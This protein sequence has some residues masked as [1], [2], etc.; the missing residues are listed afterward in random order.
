MPWVLAP[1]YWP[2]RG[3]AGLLWLQDLSIVGAE[4]AAFAWICD[5]AGQRCRR[6][7][8]A[9]EP[10]TAACVDLGRGGG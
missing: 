4:S 2:F 1:F 10:G 5:M 6:K 8:A 3:G 7:D 9:V